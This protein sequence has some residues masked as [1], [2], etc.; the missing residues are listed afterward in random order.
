MGS[1]GT[2]ARVRRRT[3]VVA[4]V[5]ASLIGLTVPLLVIAFTISAAFLFKEMN[6]LIRASLMVLFG[7]AGLGLGT[8]ATLKIV[9]RMRSLLLREK[10]ED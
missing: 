10:D 3:V 7:L 4:M 2:K 6:V 1:G 9:E 8:L 5:K